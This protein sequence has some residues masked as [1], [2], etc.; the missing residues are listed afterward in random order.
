MAD[1]LTRVE[2]GEITRLIINVPPRSLKSICVSV[3][4]PA[5][6]LGKN[7]SAKIIVASYNNHLSHKHAIDCRHLIRSDFY[8]DV[9]PEMIISDDQNQKY[10]FITSKRGSRFATS[11]GGTITGEGGNILI[12]DDPHNALDIHSQLKR[13]NVH[14]WFRQSLSSRLDDKKKGVIIVV[15]Q[16]LHH[17]DLTGFLL[18]NQLK[19]WHHLMIPAISPEDKI[20]YDGGYPHYFKEGELLHQGREGHEEIERAKS[21]LGSFAF[22]AQ[23]LQQPIINGAGM[24]KSSWLRYYIFEPKF[25]SIILSWD[26]AIKTGEGNSYSVCTC[27][28]ETEDSFYLLD[29]NRQR[30]EYPELKREIIKMIEKWKP[31]VSLIE[32]KASGQTLLQDLRRETN[33]PF[34][35][36]KPTQ[37]KVTRFARATPLFEAGKVFLPKYRPWR[38]DYESE[39]MLFP[40][41]THSDQI[42]STSQYF[43][44]IFNCSDGKPGIKPMF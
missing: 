9:F 27:W 23:Y 12:V 42:D 28:G 26:T 22:A 17:E 11:V 41:A 35:G 1:Y 14:R 34:I 18:D 36:I 31:N 24:V 7:P 32:D 8:K 5:W 20:Y 25:L 21:E 4:F 13:E 37:D 33:L 40:C 43:N 3:T 10:K 15:M 19:S 44:Y 6:L 16:R 30:L 38:V 39:I 29:V 2:R